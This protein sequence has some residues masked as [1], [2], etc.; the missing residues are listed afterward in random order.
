[1]TAYNW[2]RKN[3][4]CQ[5]WC[6]GKYERAEGMGQFCLGLFL[7]SI[8]NLF[9]N[10]SW[11]CYHASSITAKQRSCIMLN[12]MHLV[13]KTHRSN[14]RS[15]QLKTSLRSSLGNIDVSAHLELAQL[16]CFQVMKSQLNLRVYCKAR[17]KLYLFSSLLLLMHMDTV[18]FLWLSSKH[19]FVIHSLFLLLRN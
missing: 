17:W 18:S 3:S 6:L 14:F 12:A 11:K 15:W 13:D 16:K 10:G 19:S 1:M 2:R 4:C 5:D 9:N 7:F 8:L